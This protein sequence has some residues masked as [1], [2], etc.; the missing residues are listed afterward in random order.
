M[1]LRKNPIMILDDSTSSLDV[2]TEY[3]F[4]KNFHEMLEQ[5]PRKHT[6]IWITQRLSTLKNVDRIIIFNRGR[7]FEQG[8]HKDLL[9]NGRI[10]PLLWKTLETGQVDIKLTLEKIFQERGE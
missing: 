3:Q 2:H 1:I 9:K 6:V 7:I 8:S 10:Y 5:S 4:L